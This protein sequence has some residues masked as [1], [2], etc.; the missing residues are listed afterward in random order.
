M[1]GGTHSMAVV[2]RADPRTLC[3]QCPDGARWGRGGTRLLVA[4][5]VRSFTMCFFRDGAVKGESEGT[6]SGGDD[7]DDDDKST[8]C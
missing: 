6:G 8:V 1:G 5:V 2:V 7:A 3:I 4:L